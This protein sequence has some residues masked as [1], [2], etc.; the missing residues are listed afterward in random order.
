MAIED[1]KKALKMGRKEYQS[2][3]SKRFGK[4]IMILIGSQP[5]N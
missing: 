1:Y 5:S 2:N 3:L 4:K